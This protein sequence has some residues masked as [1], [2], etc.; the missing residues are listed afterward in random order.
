MC[1]IL[2]AEKARP[3]R[4]LIDAACSTNP[5]G[6]GIA[7]IERKHVVWAKGLSTD[8]FQEAVA[9]APFPFIAHARIATVGGT[10]EEL[11]HP[12][13]IEPAAGG[14]QTS[15]QAPAVLFHNGT[16][17]AWQDHLL[18]AMVRQDAPM[19]AGLWNDSRAMAWLV[20]RFGYGLLQ[21][22]PETQRTAVLTLQGIYSYG[23]NWT[24]VAEGLFASNTRW[25]KERASSS[26][27]GPRL[28]EDD[29]R[30]FA[31]PAKRGRKRATKAAAS[32]ARLLGTPTL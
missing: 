6:N 12:F 5:D 9:R 7:W 21:T 1:V 27:C 26:S 25:R 23:K 31:T 15:G 24:K 14:G 22:F 11:C 13:P 20:H 8:D 10:P 19:P 32:L 16:W 29:R 2:L 3:S 17:D 4:S 18:A 30:P 28:L